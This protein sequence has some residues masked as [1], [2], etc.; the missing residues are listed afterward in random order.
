MSRTLVG[1]TSV[2]DCAA[3]AGTITTDAELARLEMIWKGVEAEIRRFCGQNIMQPVDAY[4]DFLPET[5]RYVPLDPLLQNDIAWNGR[6]TSNMSGAPAWD[7]HVLPLK[8]GLVRSITEVRVDTTGSGGN[9][10]DDFP[11]TSVL[12]DS[13]YFLDVDEKDPSNLL[14]S[15]SGNLILK[16]GTW[17]T[18]RR[19]IKVTYV[20][21]FTA[22]EMD[23]E[24]SD[25]RLA[26]TEEVLDRYTSLSSD[27]VGKVKQERLGDWEVTYAISENEGRLS[28]SLKDALRPFV[29]WKM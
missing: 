13:Y 1:I 15:W 2:A 12:D 29:K 14:I 26:V 4:V 21:G 24:F 11:S 18:R 5:D 3:L 16:S 6:Y 9:D 10:G 7:G 27:G 23:D 19:S 8:Q 22:A 17:S 28:S 25:I 20:A